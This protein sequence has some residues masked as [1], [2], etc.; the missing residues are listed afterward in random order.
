MNLTKALQGLGLSQSETRI[1]LGLL[2]HGP[3]T[4]ADMARTT[5][6]YRPVVYTC[7]PKLLE[8]NLISRL[9]KGKRT[10][11][12][13]CSPNHL[14][15]LFSALRNRL[16]TILPKLQK[17]F[18]K[19]KTAKPQIFVFE[20]REGIKQT[21]ID[22]IESSKKG[23]VIYRYESP[24]DY[25]LNKRY[26]PALYMRHAGG[27]DSEIQKFVLTNEK[28]HNQRRQQLSRYS[29]SIQRVQDPFEYN[30]TQIIYQDKVL[31]IDYETRISIVFQN[32][33]FADF[34]KKIFKLLFYKL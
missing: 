9:V 27:T 25:K 24:K 21:Y 30:I 32:Q 4:V 16:E 6:L 3:S 15:Q 26:Y 14:T 31:F 1:Y 12:E 10:Y 33:R 19:L 34:Q 11:Y 29:K 7:L 22:L 17:K 8:L 13:V 23:D 18:E 2:E 20:G 5:A 28:T